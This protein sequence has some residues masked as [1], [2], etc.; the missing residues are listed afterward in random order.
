MLKE[1]DLEAKFEMVFRELYES[2]E[3]QSELGKNIKRM[4][5]PHA[6]SQIVDEIEKLIKK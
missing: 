2:K 3:K 4:A 1:K 5:M 6:T